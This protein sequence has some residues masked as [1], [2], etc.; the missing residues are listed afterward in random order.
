MNA[1]TMIRE[2]L[3]FLLQHVPLGDLHQL[4]LQ[5]EQ[6]SIVEHICKPT[7]QNLLVPVHDPINQGLF[8]S[9]EVLVTSAVMREIGR[10][11]C[12]ERVS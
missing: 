3:N 7:S 6:E 12:R 10:A 4:C 5:I 9:G 11:S 1:K 8:Y 2:Q